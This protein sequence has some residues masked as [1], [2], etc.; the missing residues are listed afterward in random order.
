MLRLAVGKASQ[1]AEV[2]PVRAGRIAAVPL[3]QDPGHHRRLLGRDGLL[4]HPDPGLVMARARLDHICWRKPV[5]LEADDRRR[6]EIVQ[7]DEAD[8]PIGPDVDVMAV[9]VHPLEPWDPVLELG[10]GPGAQEHLPLHCIADSDLVAGAG[11]SAHLRGHRAVGAITGC[12]DGP[13]APAGHGW[14]PPPLA[15]ACAGRTGWPQV[16]TP[17]KLRSARR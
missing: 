13:V 16:S 12:C 1:A 2:T 17:R 15:E 9:G 3:D 4:G 6:V 11:H 8:A 5:V 14:V 10:N 7:Q